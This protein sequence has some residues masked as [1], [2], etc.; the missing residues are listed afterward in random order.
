M[1]VALA[2]GVTGGY[3][4]RVVEWKDFVEQISP[5]LDNA[6][7]IHFVSLAIEKVDSKKFDLEDLGDV[8]TRLQSE[9]EA[10]TVL[11]FASYFEEKFFSLMSRHMLHISSKKAKDALF[12]VNGPLNSFY[13]RATMAF[14][15]G[16]ISASTKLKIDALRKIRNQ[17][18]HRAFSASFADAF[19]EQQFSIICDD[20][21]KQIHPVL[22]ASERW[23][24]TLGYSIEWETPIEGNARKLCGLALLAQSTFVEML[25]IPVSRE[26]RVRSQDLTRAGV[27]DQC[28]RSSLASLLNVLIALGHIT[29]IERTPAE[30]S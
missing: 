27:V 30:G 16:W 6:L 8:F 7:N 15:L 9:S 13:S 29:K 25:T 12:G 18:A 1:P 5:Y 24:S 3:M 22:H 26:M 23:L 19:I 17:F 11:I 10:A 28:I 20:L 2:S 21:E 4:A 14:H